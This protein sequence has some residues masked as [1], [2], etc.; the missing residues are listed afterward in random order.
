MQIATNLPLSPLARMHRWFGLLS[1][2][3]LLSL[4]IISS[5]QKCSASELKTELE[6]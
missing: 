6:D 5:F 2:V 3:V 1:T 4:D